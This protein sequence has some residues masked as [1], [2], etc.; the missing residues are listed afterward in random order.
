MTENG[1]NVKIPAISMKIPASYED[2]GEVLP[3]SL[4][5]LVVCWR[6]KDLKKRLLDGKISR[7]VFSFKKKR[8]KN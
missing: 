7:F 1:G 8:R 5:L 4:I 6:L 3:F 2:S